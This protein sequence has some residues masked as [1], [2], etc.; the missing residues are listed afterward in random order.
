MSCPA[1]KKRLPIIERDNLKFCPAG[2]VMALYEELCDVCGGCSS[3]CDC[4]PEDLGEAEEIVDEEDPLFE[5]EEA[6]R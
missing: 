2:L 1:A 6:G 3:C 4:T 5:P